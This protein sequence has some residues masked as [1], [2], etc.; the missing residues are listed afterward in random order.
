M[1]NIKWGCCTRPQKKDLGVT[2][3]ADSF[4]AASKGNQIQALIRRTMTY[5]EKQL[6]VALYKAIFWANLEYCIEDY[7]I[8]RT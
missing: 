2:F 3:S 5:K 6:I 7:I 4:R 8:R 1:K